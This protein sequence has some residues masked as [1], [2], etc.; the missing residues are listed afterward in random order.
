MRRAALAAGCTRAR[1]GVRR[2][3]RSNE[4]RALGTVLYHLGLSLRDAPTVIDVLSG[5]SHEAVRE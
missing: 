3:R 2:A 4:L 5:A 1:K